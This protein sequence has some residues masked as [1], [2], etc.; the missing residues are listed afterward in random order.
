MLQLGT[1]PLE[2]VARTVITYGL[3]FAALRAFGEREI[4][5]SRSLISRWCCS[6]RTRSSLRSAVPIP[7]S[8]VARIILGTIFALNVTLSSLRVRVPSVA[9]LLEFAPTVIGRDGRWLTDVMAREGIDLGDAEA[10]LREHG[11]DDVN[12]LRLATLEEDGSISIVAVDDTAGPAARR[13]RRRYRR[14]L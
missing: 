6:P 2:L 1:P 7:R 13:R 11:I 14:P 8:P 5:S 9:R 12:E 10:A 3:F 4:G